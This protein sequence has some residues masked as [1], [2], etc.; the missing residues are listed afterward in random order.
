[1]R[2]LVP[3]CAAITCNQRAIGENCHISQQMV[4]LIECTGMSESFDAF[5]CNTSKTLQYPTMIFSWKQQEAVLN[6][7]GHRD[8]NVREM[9]FLEDLSQIFDWKNMQVVDVGLNH[10]F[11]YINVAP[12]FLSFGGKILSLITSRP[13]DQ[14]TFPSFWPHHVWVLYLTTFNWLNILNGWSP[15][16]S[17]PVF[18]YSVD[19]IS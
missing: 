1:M 18:L 14:V 16:Y 15:L 5:P 8:A 4:T 9:G 13:N 6:G 19:W 11:G 7:S 10:I 2:G 17:G 12:I 3:Y